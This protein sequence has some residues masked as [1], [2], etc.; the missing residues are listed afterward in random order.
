MFVPFLMH[1]W[2]RSCLSVIRC[3]KP[4]PVCVCRISRHLPVHVRRTVI[5]PD[6]S[7]LTQSVLG[8]IDGAMRSILGCTVAR[9]ACSFHCPTGIHKLIGQALPLCFGQVR[10]GGT[11]QP[12]TPHN[13][14]AVRRSKRRGRSAA[15][16]PSTPAGSTRQSERAR[17]LGP[18][19]FRESLPDQSEEQPAALS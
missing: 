17:G 1:R 18:K 8:Q 10:V 6:R 11:P 12:T 9:G 16:C 15:I 2:R 14:A 4:E 3:L 5:P 7:T 13:I 19:L